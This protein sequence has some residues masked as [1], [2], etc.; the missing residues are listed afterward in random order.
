MDMYS[1]KPLS[2]ENFRKTF[3]RWKSVRIVAE[4]EQREPKAKDFQIKAVRRVI[5]DK[6]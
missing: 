3:L 1:R 4:Q 5:V 2:V 6:T